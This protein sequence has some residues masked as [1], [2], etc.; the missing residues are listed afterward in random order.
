MEL[1]AIPGRTLTERITL[2]RP[3][4]TLPD[5]SARRVVP[6][7]SLEPLVHRPAPTSVYIGLVAT[8]ALAATTVAVGAVALSNKGAFNDAND[9]TNPARA[10]EIRDTGVGLNLATDVLLGASLAA[11]AVTGVLYLTRPS[12]PIDVAIVPSGTGLSAV[13]RF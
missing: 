11:A 6:I 10:M 7:T 4:L 1:E 8:G 9:G 2:R 3:K 5:D 13:G 12:V